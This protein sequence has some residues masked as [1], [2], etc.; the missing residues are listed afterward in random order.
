MERRLLPAEGADEL[1]SVG[2]GR[3]EGGLRF[4]L[5]VLH[6]FFPPFSLNTICVRLWGNIHVHALAAH[7]LDNDLTTANDSHPNGKIVPRASPPKKKTQ[8]LFLTIDHRTQ[9]RRTVGPWS[10]QQCHSEACLITNINDSYVSGSAEIE[11]RGLRAQGKPASSSN[12]ARGKV[13][14]RKARRTAEDANQE[15]HK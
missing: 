1:P 14:E 4:P 2:G 15:L 9:L 3:E 6:H 5:L 12:E 8:P 7:Q 10:P 11:A 13:R